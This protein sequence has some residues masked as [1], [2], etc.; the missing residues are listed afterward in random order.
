MAIEFIRPW[1]TRVG[2]N[3]GG[4]M[5]GGFED[6]KE[7][8]VVFGKPNSPQAWKLGLGDHQ[9]DRAFK[10]LY[11]ELRAEPV[12]LAMHKITADFEGTDSRALYTNSI[13]DSYILGLY[14][15]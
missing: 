7:L 12:R 5:E 9:V 1:M 8:T 15:E 6:S 4:T 13:P 10:R 2:N 11:Q 14:L 3:D